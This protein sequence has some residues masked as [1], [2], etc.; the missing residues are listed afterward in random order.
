MTGDNKLGRPTRTSGKLERSCL[1]NERRAARGAGGASAWLFG[2]RAIDV[3]GR[4][5][6]NAAPW[7]ARKAKRSAGR[8]RRFR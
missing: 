7:I 8:N 2:E 4:Q 3:P 6:R 5:S 1:R